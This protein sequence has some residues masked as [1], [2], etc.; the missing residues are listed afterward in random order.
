MKT[1]P[2][3]ERELELLDTEEGDA[4]FFAR[5]GLAGE[6]IF[7]LFSSLYG[8]HPDFQDQLARLLATLRDAYRARPERLKALDRERERSEPWY[9]KPGLAAYMLY[10]DRFAGDLRGFERKIP[11]L[12]ELGVKL[13]H[14][15]PFWRCPAGNSDGGYAISDYLLVDPRLGAEA[16]LVETAD[17][18]HRRGMYLAADLVLNHSADDHPWALA[19]KA[20]DRR[21]REYYYV[22]PD[23]TMPDRFEA[24]MPEVFPETAPGNFTWV[25]ELESWV[26][27]VFHPFQWDL[28]WSNPE[29]FLEML[30]VLAGM[31]NMGIDLIRLD[32]VPYL[33]KRPGTSCQNLDEAHTIVR[34]LKACALVVAPGVAFLAEAIVQPSEIV[35]YLDTAEADE[36]QLA[37]HASLM[38]LLWEALA[39]RKASLL[40]LSLGEETRLASGTAWLSYVRCHD[41]IGLG[42]DDRRIE[43][44]GYEPRLHRR[45]LLDYYSGRFPGSPASGRLFMENPNTGDARISGSCA[46]LAGLETAL[47]SGDE[48]AVEL[49]LRRIELLYGLAC[50]IVGI[51]MLFAGDE[52]GLRNDYSWESVSELAEDNRWMHRPIMDWKAAGRRKK[53]GSLEARLFG[54]IARYL[55]LRTAIPAFAQDA[56]F[57]ILPSPGENLFLCLRRPTRAEGRATAQG[58]ANAGAGNS[59]DAEPTE[60]ERPWVLVAANF[61]PEPRRLGAA[62]LPFA[63]SGSRELLSD[64]PLVDGDPALEAYGLLW[65]ELSAP[66]SP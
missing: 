39:T 22:F 66:G 9:L 3:I 53:P 36:C 30:G 57:E 2:R 52:I 7:E 34:L 63:L 32:A 5:L 11:Y 24:A 56:P 27:T 6:A 4:A 12:E 15:M 50:S 23:R 26:M 14:L 64:R 38:A 42:Y 44:V 13:V 58:R 51:P 31:A 25:P 60:G 40:S 48:A 17:K 41:D 18:L 65:I 49:A 10:L 59:A 28:N 29:L 47:A 37:Y 45:F 33:W 61:A 35:R 55:A 8:D 20:G 46:S 19:A 54:R 43:R 21:H 62:A 16:E 1:H